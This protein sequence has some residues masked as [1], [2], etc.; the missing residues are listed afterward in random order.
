MFNWNFDGTR[1]YLLWQNVDHE[2][3]TGDPIYVQESRW[4]YRWSQVEVILIFKI[5]GQIT[6]L[7]QH[8]RMQENY[9]ASLTCEKQG[10]C[11]FGMFKS[12]EDLSKQDFFIIINNVWSELVTVC[13]WP[14][15]EN[16]ISEMRN[17]FTSIS[18]MIAWDK[19]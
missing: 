12:L 18:L 11:G 10:F 2:I 8:Q 13:C 7:T 17:H 4:K 14:F 9:T 6:D 3:S 5:E 16:S 15:P 1:V 19:S